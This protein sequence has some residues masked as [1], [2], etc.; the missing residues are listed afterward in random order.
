M[1]P[2]YKYTNV[3]TYVID[4]VSQKV[5]EEE[6]QAFLIFKAKADLFISQLI[7]ADEKLKNL[8]RW[9]LRRQIDTVYQIMNGQQDTLIKILDAQHNFEIA[10]DEYLGRQTFMSIVLPDG[11]PIF[12]DSEHIGS[13]VYSQAT[14][15]KGRGNIDFTDKQFSP[16]LDIFHF[17]SSMQQSLQEKIKISLANKKEVYTEALNKYRKN[18]YDR[19]HYP[20]RSESSE[21][22]LYWRTSSVE[23]HITGWSRLLPHAGVIAEGYMEAVLNDDENVNN[24]NIEASI[25]YMYDKYIQLDSIPAA[26]KA[27]V[28]VIGTNVEIA[29]K[30]GKFSTARLGQFFMLAKNIQ[31]L[32]PYFTKEQ[33][34]MILPKLITQSSKSKTGFTNVADA[35]V[36]AANKQGMIILEKRIKEE[37]KEGITITKQAD[38]FITT[39]TTIQKFLINTKQ[40]LKYI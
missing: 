8:R 17:A 7:K 40:S 1:A 38:R 20:S 19:M 35:I 22:T 32:Q 21:R 25:A 6:R 29:I 18:A 13:E 16:N 14:G 33:F 10:L 34:K 4:F 3:E 9:K 31:R 11:T 24:N 28:Q 23:T 37:V 12:Y 5:S 15:N 27:D 30:E 36:N 26:V 39:K 2:K